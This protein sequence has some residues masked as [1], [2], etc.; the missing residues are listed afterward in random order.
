M[1]RALATVKELHGY[2]TA[3]IAERQR[4]P[5]SDLL[6]ELIRAEDDSRGGRLTTDELFQ[7]VVFLFLAGHH[8]TTNLIG[9]GMLALVRR[10]EEMDRLRREPGLVTTAIDELL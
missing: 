10:P 4:S 7:I 5:G 3:L 8:T 6:S 2:F 1:K 9:N